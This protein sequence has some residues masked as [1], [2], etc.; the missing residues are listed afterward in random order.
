MNPESYRL[1]K[2]IA[3]R[4]KLAL[5][6]QSEPFGSPAWIAFLTKLD[7]SLRA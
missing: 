1:L 7:Q 6:V 4:K 2:S 3:D 5:P